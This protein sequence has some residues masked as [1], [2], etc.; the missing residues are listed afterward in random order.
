M[1]LN[2]IS[3]VSDSFEEEF[4]LDAAIEGLGGGAL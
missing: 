4:A 3:I 2:A 1:E